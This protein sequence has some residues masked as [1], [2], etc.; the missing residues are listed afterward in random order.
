MN[1]DP[2]ILIWQLI[3]V[4]AAIITVLAVVILGYCLKLVPQVL[5]QRIPLYIIITAS[6]LYYGMTDPAPKTHQDII[7]TFVL[8]LFIGVVAWQFH[9]Q[10]LKRFVD[11]KLPLLQDDKP[12]PP[13]P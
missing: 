1:Q 2:T 3:Q 4:K 8:G 6:V 12:Q 7:L 11:S 13:K 9:A 10:L 5:N